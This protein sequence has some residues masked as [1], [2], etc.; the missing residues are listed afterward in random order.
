M[1]DTRK[2]VIEITQGNGGSSN[3]PS[4]K[5]K[6]NKDF[7]ELLHPLKKLKTE[8]LGENVLINQAFDTA[9]KAILNSVSVTAN[10][11]FNLK[12]DYLS[13]NLVNNALTAVGKVT[14]FGSAVASGAILGSSVTGIGTAVGA[15]I[16]ATG[17]VVNEGISMYGQLSNYY[18]SINATTYQTQFS[19]VRAGLINEGR[20]TEN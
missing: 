14:S 17:W 18:Q 10:R 9:K 11:Y 4:N 1:A 19:R 5:N 15:A 7:Q 20:G 8:I 6:V 16:A 2:I 12:E 13:E 3:Q